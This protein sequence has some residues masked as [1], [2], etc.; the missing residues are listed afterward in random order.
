MET[1]TPDT[2]K[3]FQ[4]ETDF[5][6][7]V[8]ANLEQAKGRDFRGSLWQRARYDETD[9]LRALMAANR[10]YDRELLKSLPANRRVA[11]LGFERR[12]WFG[13]RRTGVAIASVL[14][15]LN[16]YVSSSDRP[17]PP[18]GVSEL[19]DHVNR[20]VGDA[21]VPHI[22]GVC[23][24]S[25]F[26]EEARRTR[27]DIANTA[28]VLVEPDGSGGWRTTAAGDAVDPRLLKI[29][30]PEGAKQKVD[31]VRRLIE[32]RSA[33]LLTGGLSASSVARAVNLPEDVV[34]QGFDQVAATDPELR[35]SKKDGEFLLFRGAPLRPQEKRS[36]NVIDRIRQLFSGEGD[37]AAKINLLAER[38][39]ALAQRR[40]RI[41]EDIGKL[42]QKDA[43]LLAQG[44]AATSAV[45]RRRLAAQI[46]QLRKDIVRQNTTA[47]MLN[48]QI[49][50]I[51]TDIHNL[52][53]IQQGQMAELPDTAE[54]TEHAVEA[55]ELLESLKA[56]AE[57][58]G[59][60]E[61]GTALAGADELAILKEFEG[62]A[63][64]AKTAEASPPS[65]APMRTAPAR[66]DVRAPAAPRMDEPKS[67]TPNKSRRPAD[68]EPT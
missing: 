35:V 50:I 30:D 42:E 54:L 24:P 46:A 14:S 34:R 49:N 55:E 2:A 41:Y 43:D 56:D 31:R 22:I 6:A 47:A 59:S 15:P 68:P 33:D 32:E 20:L 4:C 19:V 61:M 67:A 7:A 51:S 23:S 11:L 12:W 17:A 53:L 16:H 18:I 10:I 13:K 26:T 37:E 52:T 21:K 58:V 57:L 5:L 40:D 36:M 38:R 62:D 8:E 44:K 3:A 25:G 48:Q 64:K 29:F 60:L 66:E 28:V 27:L 63:G 39:A 45:P 9:R 1:M 65:A